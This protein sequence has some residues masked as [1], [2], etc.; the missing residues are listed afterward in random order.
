MR[1]S[2]L[3][4][5]AAAAAVLLLL[6][7]VTSLNPSSSASSFVVLGNLQSGGNIGRIIRSASIFGVEECV[8]VGQRKWPIMGDH[9]SRFDVAQRHFYD[10][11]S[12]AAYLK[13]ERGATIVGV[14]ITDSS[15]PLAVLDPATG[16]LSAPWCPDGGRKPVAFVFGNE[17]SGLSRNFRAICDDFV[18]IP[19][20][21]G[22]SGGSAGSEGGGGGSGTRGGGGS[23]SGTSG[24]GSSS[25]NV[26]CAAAVVLHMHALV[27]GLPEA[28]RQGEKFTQGSGQ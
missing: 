5:A 1:F 22:G 6:P 18:Y 2:P 13:E 11:A 3:V 12:A 10:H 21:R 19:Q 15:K 16:R 28:Q 8:V 14:E 17:G 26:A 24:G 23:G 7:S 27:A 20:H 4:L 9:G 25:L